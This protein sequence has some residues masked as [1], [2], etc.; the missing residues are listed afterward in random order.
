MRTSIQIAVD[1]LA[2]LLR[3]T[4]TRIVF[5]ES[6][7]AGLVAASLAAIPGIS[8]FLCGSAVTY[9][10]GTKLAWLGIPSELLNNP[11][12]TAVSPIVAEMMSQGVLS[13]TPEADFAL[14]VTGHLGPGSPV[15]LDGTI[16][17]GVAR[18]GES[19]VQVTSHQLS[20]RAEPGLTL[21]QTRQHQAVVLVLRAAV[22]AI[23]SSRGINN[24]R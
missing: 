17:I 8:E 24:D 22:A 7:T 9:R 13:K 16:L 20:Y 21:R 23:A 2:E 5:A 6:C 15:K 12:I 4:R 14:S 1:E 18:R 19:P 3:R 11:E 10:D